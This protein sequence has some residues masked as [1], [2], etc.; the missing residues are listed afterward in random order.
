MSEENVEL[1]R[2]I[3]EGG[4][5]SDVEITPDVEYVNPPE[6]IEPGLRRGRDE[7]TRALQKASESFDTVRY[8]VHDLYDAGDAVIGSV[9]FFARLGG[10][11][12]E[13]VQDEV[14]TWTFRDGKLARFEWGR[15]LK[16]AL[17]AAGLSER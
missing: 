12:T 16:A 8:E 3:Y 2:R 4:D 7:V 14:H 17:E 13:V 15:D 6:A 10:S 9:S 11:D 1:V 5:L